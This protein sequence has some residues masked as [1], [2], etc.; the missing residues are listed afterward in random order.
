M[1][2]SPSAVAQTVV[3]LE[4]RGLVE[5]TSDPND[6]RVTLLR[7]SAKSQ[8]KLKSVKQAARA[9]LDQLMSPLTDTEL[10]TLLEL[11]AK[12]SGGADGAG[13]GGAADGAA[14]GHPTVG[15]AAT[16]GTKK[17]STA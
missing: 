14:A 17:G 12:M 2:V 9:R 16:A 8:A 13:A 15:A 7:P 3:V 5:R 1:G 4:Q 10:A 11:I 6:R